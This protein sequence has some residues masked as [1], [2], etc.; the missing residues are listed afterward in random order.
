VGDG[1]CLANAA[2]MGS[3]IQTAGHVYIYGIYFDTGKAD[4][5]SESQAAVQAL[6]RSHD[7]AATRLKAQGA[8]QIAPVASNRAEEPQQFKLLK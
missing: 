3:D 2:A 6:I 7:V 1:I 4:V 5:K 8:E